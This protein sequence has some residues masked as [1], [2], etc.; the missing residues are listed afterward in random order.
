MIIIRIIRNRRESLL[1]YEE[2]EYLE[3]DELGGGAFLQVDKKHYEGQA[4][5][6]EE[7][8]VHVLPPC[9]TLPHLVL[10]VEGAVDVSETCFMRVGELLPI[11]IQEQAIGQREEQAQAHQQDAQR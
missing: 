10:F 1:T 8:R 5:H 9:A 11:L 6:C 4:P 2:V 3:G 7:A